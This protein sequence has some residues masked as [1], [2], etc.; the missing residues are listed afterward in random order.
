[1][2]SPDRLEAS[3]SLSG[4]LAQHSGQDSVWPGAQDA[5]LE[6][7]E[8]TSDEASQGRV[9]NGTA[10]VA[11]TEGNKDTKTVRMAS[12][13]SVTSAEFNT[14]AADGHR[15]ADS[16]S[17]NANGATL[18][19]KRSRSGSI[20]RSESPSSNLPIPPR[21]TLSDKIL[22]DQY[23][24]REFQHAAL[25]AWEN[26]HQELLQQK[27]AERDYYLSIQ[28]ERQINPGAIFGAGYEGYGNARTDLKSQHPQLL[29]PSNRRRPGG[30]KAKDLRISRDDMTTQAEQ[31]EDLVPI[32]LDID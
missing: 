21:E 6:E 8:I 26:P 11:V 9:L 16:S 13:V 17:G 29:Y 19:R 2:L 32:R 5:P 23:V 4:G 22:L 15:S 28:H 24:N 14:A 20:I 30:R 31:I 25:A 18:S 7:V 10:A 27:R 12:G 3:S 1:M